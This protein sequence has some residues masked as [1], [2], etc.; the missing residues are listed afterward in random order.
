MPPSSSKPRNGGETHIPERVRDRGDAC[1]GALR[2]HRADDGG[3][4]RLRLPVGVLTSHQITALADA[5]D[6][7]GDGHLGVT[8]RGNLDLRGLPDDCGL[9]LA[10]LLDAAG[11]LPS[12]AHE[13]IR[14]MVVSPLAG[15][16][17]RGHAD[18]QAWAR[19]LDALLC[20]EAWTTAL[21]GRFLFAVDDGRGDVAGLGADVTLLAEPD[22]RAVL[23]VGDAG[24]AA[25]VGGAVGGGGTAEG[26]GGT[27]AAGGATAGGAVGGTWRVA[28]ADAPRAALAV[29]R[30]FLAVAR[31]AGTGAWRVAELPADCGLGTAVTRHLADA[32]VVAWPEAAW[33]APGTATGATGAIAGTGTGTATDAAPEPGVVGE[34]GAVSVVA[35]LG[36]VTTAQF[37]A[38]DPGPAGEVRVTPWRGFVVTGLPGRAAAVERLAALEAAGYLVRAGSP[39]LSVSACTGRPGCGKALADVRADARPLEHGL[40]VHWSGCARRCG[41]PQGDWVDALATSDGTYEITVRTAPGTRP[42]APAA[43]PTDTTHN[44]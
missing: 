23:R 28:G 14:N 22:G 37:R 25:A 9:A 43:S 1:P 30:A 41:H 12:A 6:R 10:E 44:T 17:G 40:P 26:G 32:G 11:L 21:S 2:L 5:A 36:R 33:P 20:A 16:D 42:P 18:A 19:E 8:S 13:R 24:G 34:G 39:W 4:A 27:A 29:A 35:P 15:L 38:L 31:E 7:L 3:L